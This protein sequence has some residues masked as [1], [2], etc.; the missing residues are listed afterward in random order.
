MKIVL[1]DF[2][3]RF[4]SALLAG[5]L[6]ALQRFLQRLIVFMLY[7]GGEPIGP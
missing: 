5:H 4:L 7:G 3:L 2:H 6:E 1:K